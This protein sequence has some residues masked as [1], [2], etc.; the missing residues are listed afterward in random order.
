LWGSWGDAIRHLWSYWSQLET[1]THQTVTF[2]RLAAEGRCCC[3]VQSSLT[4]DVVPTK[5]ERKLRDKRKKAVAT[6]QE[7]LDRESSYATPDSDRGGAPPTPPIYESMAALLEERAVMRELWA[8]R[9][10]DRVFREMSQEYRPLP[11]PCRY[12]RPMDEK[13]TTPVDEQ[14]SSPMPGTPEELRQVAANLRF[15]G[16]A[17]VSG[18]AT[19]LPKLTWPEPAA[20]NVDRSDNHTRAADWSGWTEYEFGLEMQCPWAGA[21]LQG[22]KA[23]ETRAYDLPPALRGQKIV[24]IETPKGKEG[25]GSSMGNQVDFA[26]TSDTKIVGWCKFSSV[27]KYTSSQDFAR[28]EKAH[29]VHQSSGFGWK[30]GT[31]DLI[32]G[33]VVSECGGVDDE[34]LASRYKSGTRRLRSLYQLTARE[35]KDSK[36][37]QGNHKRQHGKAKSQSNS[38]SKKE[39]KRRF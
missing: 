25:G 11:R 39:K 38:G 29:L 12:G 32:Y 9:E 15:L 3:C 5:A 16:R 28:D 6:M 35:N 37:P 8:K 7:L 33:W 23:I 19:D 26:T 24:I 14:G 17:F 21:L 10:K 27:K 18:N 2:L 4:S 20:R 31:T 36:P 1:R 22:R 13:P 34:T 30:E